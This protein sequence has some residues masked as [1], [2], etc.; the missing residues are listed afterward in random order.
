MDHIVTIRPITGPDELDL[1]RLL[2]Y[3]IDHELADDLAEGR[4]EP[5]WMWVALR[6]DRLLARAAWWGRAGEGTP[7]LLDVFDVDDTSPDRVDIG[8]RL[9][10]TAMAAVVPAGARPPA[11][12]RA[13]P[14]DWRESGPPCPTG[15]PRWSGPAPACSPN[16]CA[17]SGCRAPRSPSPAAACGSARSATPTRSST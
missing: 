10:R 15:W 16:A 2:S 9:L 8:E 1:F 13:A 11:Y 6:G 12:H 17:W 3:A 14:P 4:R 7:S 5:G